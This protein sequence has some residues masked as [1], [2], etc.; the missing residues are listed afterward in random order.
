TRAILLLMCLFGATSCETRPSMHP[1]SNTVKQPVP[2]QREVEEYLDIRF[3]ECRNVH[4]HKAGMIPLGIYTTLISF[5]VPKDDLT[6]LLEQSP[7]LPSYGEFVNNNAKR[8]A[9]MGRREKVIDWWRPT[10]LEKPVTAIKSWCTHREGDECIL[11]AYACVAF[12][13]IESGWVR[14]YINVG[15]EAWPFP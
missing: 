5:E 12:A 2:H 11:Y 1:Y 14:V 6:V 3:L 7:K 9:V 8:M 10:E 15:H 13:E 4:F